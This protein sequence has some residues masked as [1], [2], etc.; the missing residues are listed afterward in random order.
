MPTA[1]LL[2]VKDV[3]EL[4]YRL[5]TSSFLIPTPG[6]ASLDERIAALWQSLTAR[7]SP[8]R[9]ARVA[10]TRRAVGART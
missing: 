6:S 2:S 10:R 5:V 3:L 7:P 8:V 1:R 9:E 4:F